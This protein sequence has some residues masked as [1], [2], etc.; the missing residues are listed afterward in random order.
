MNFLKKDRFIFDLDRTIWDTYD[1]HGNQIWA[2]QMVPPYSVI[3]SSTIRD[4]IGSY[5]ILKPG[6][7]EFLSFLSNNNKKIGFLSCGAVYGFEKVIQPSLILL[8]L[9]NIKQC[10]NDIEILEYKTFSK[11]DYLKNE[12]ECVFF[13]DDEKHLNA[14]KTLQHVDEIDAKEIEWAKICEL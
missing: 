3:D 14:V 2:K 11:H 5:C 7:S 12:P 9:F 10:F 1:V 8:E 4:D 6:V 13:D